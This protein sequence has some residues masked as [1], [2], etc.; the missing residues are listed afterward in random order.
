[1]GI[2]ELNEGPLHATLKSYYAANGGAVEV[3]MEG[4]V[5]D[6][7]RGGIIYEVQTGSFSGLQRKLSHLVTLGPVVLVHPIASNSTIVKV[8]ESGEIISRR[9]SP[10]HGELINIV[11][12]LVYIPQLINE[13]NLSVE[14]VLTD[15]EEIR[16]YDPNKRRGRGG[17]RVQARVLKDIVDSKRIGGVAELWDF[18]GD[19]L[20]EPFTTK[21]LA[22]ALAKPVNIAQ[23]MAYCLRHAQA[24]EIVGKQGNALL[25]RSV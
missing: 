25:Y 23:Q 12:Q 18:V 5:A 19:E 3:P 14:V 1:M 22:Q 10:K 7:V 4:Y 20:K 24:V 9:K 11:G 6:A 13:P 17:W 15:E 2:G 16:T 8:D 21:E